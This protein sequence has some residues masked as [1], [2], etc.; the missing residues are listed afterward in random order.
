M[1]SLLVHICSP[2]EAELL[3]AQ[4]DELAQSAALPNPFFES[5]MLLPALS[6]LRGEE[7][8]SLLTVT[9][10]AAAGEPLIGLF[11]V[12]QKRGY[13]GLKVPYLEVWRYSHCYFAVPLIRAGY[14]EQ[15]WKALFRWFDKASD[16]PYFMRFPEFACD[17][18]VESSLLSQ[19]RETG[20]YVFQVQTYERASLAGCHEVSTYRKEVLG[21]RAKQFRQKEKKLAKEGTLKVEYISDQ[22]DLIVWLDRFL[23]LEK[24][25]WKGRR[26]TA[27]ASTAT[28]EKFFRHIMEHAVKRGS[29]QMSVLL[30]GSQIAA[31]RTGF[32]SGQYEYSYKIAYNESLGRFSPGVLLELSHAENFLGRK[33]MVLLDSCATPDVRML[34]QVFKDKR[35]IA[36]YEV[37]AARLT[38]KLF[39]R[40]I[41]LLTSAVRR[42]RKKKTGQLEE[43]AQT[44]D[45]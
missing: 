13:K 35:T 38:T 43:V 16:R 8:V 28:D 45:E 42:L 17:H 20:R 31:I 29:L 27:M 34:N 3:C 32:V 4:W 44:E 22:K 10:S 9:D 6:F 21:K 39:L 14:E 11:P 1:T 15:F 36:V 24:E 26:G 18:L 2:V 40:G 41:A 25:S 30:A 7:Q 5:W 23:H 12:V 37:S 19:A 33:T